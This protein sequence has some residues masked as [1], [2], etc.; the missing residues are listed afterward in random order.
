MNDEE[1]KQLLQER[2]DEEACNLHFNPRLDLL[3][4]SDYCNSLNNLIHRQGAIWERM[5]A[6]PALGAMLPNEPGIYMFVWKPVLS[7]RFIASPESEQFTWV[8]YIGKSGTEGSTTATIRQRYLGEYNKYVGK[9]AVCLWDVADPQNR[10]EKL[11]R[12][13]TLRPL[14]F[15]YLTMNNASEILR[16]ET[17]LIRVLRPPLNKQHAVTLRS[18]KK[19]PVI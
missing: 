9:N 6:T 16:L 4:N 1:L 19:Q 11:S 12:F 3:M 15:W 5:L 14:E 13:L 8:L 17:K 7:L 10:E 18:G 2:R